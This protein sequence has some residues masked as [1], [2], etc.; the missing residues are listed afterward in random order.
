MRGAGRGGERAPG[1]AAQLPPT[2]GHRR[3]RP[4]CGEH[5]PTARAADWSPCWLQ[6]HLRRAVDQL[7]RPPH[8]ALQSG[9][10][11]PLSAAHHRPAA[12]Q[13]AGP[14][15]AR[16]RREPCH[17]HGRLPQHVWRVALGQQRGAMCVVV[18]GGGQAAA[19]LPVCAQL[20][21]IPAPLIPI[22]C[23]SCWQT[24][25]TGEAPGGASVCHSAGANLIRPA[26]RAAA[27][28]THAAAVALPCAGPTPPPL[29][30]GPTAARAT[31]SA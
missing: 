14:R 30:R 27:A 17:R 5:V 24:I 6:V 3:W 4:S 9:R 28:H 26:A 7:R 20:Q 23:C 18:C 15:L 8:P 16:H 13:R 12:A 25:M 21:P 11:Q 10:H 2:C 1:A 19:Q 22:A 31:Q 29:G